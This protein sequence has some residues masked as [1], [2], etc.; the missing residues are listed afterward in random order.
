MLINFIDFDRCE[1]LEK[2]KRDVYFILDE[3]TEELRDLIGTN[4]LAADF[5]GD[6][7]QR[8]PDDST[9]EYSIVPTVIKKPV[10]GRQL[11]GD[12]VKTLGKVNS[13]A[14]RIRKTFQRIGNGEI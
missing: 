1:I 2:Q 13:L 7:P 4:S 10:K 14:I 8:A 5:A 9:F 6:G 11:V 12:I 3:I